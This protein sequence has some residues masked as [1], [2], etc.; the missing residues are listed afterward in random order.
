MPEK[1][2][3]VDEVKAGG[4]HAMRRLQEV[5]EHLQRIRSYTEFLQE[6]LNSEISRAEKLEARLIELEATI[7]RQEIESDHREYVLRLR[8]W[9]GR[10]LFGARALWDL[11]RGF[12]F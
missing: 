7:A 10:I 11:I 6:R 12:P 1:P 4:V 9:R 8:I 2:D 5:Q 3:A